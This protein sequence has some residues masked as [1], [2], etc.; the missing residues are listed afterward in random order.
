ML[1]SDPVAIGLLE[2]DRVENTVCVFIAY[3]EMTGAFR[4]LPKALSV[5]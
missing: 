2:S 5:S 3:M 1:I 4:G